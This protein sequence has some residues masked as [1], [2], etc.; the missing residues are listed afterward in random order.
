M[1][2]MLSLDHQLRDLLLST[3]Q[4]PEKTTI[5]ARP[6]GE[7]TTESTELLDQTTK[8]APSLSLTTG[9]VPN[10]ALNPGNAEEP[11]F[12]REVDGALDM[13]AA[14]VLPSQIKLQDS[15]LTTEIENRG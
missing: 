4:P 1:L 7:V 11:D 10:S 6:S 3:F 5:T 14:K 13:M 9:W 12:A 8:T 15:H 2:N